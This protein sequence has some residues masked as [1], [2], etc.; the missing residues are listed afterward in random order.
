[1]NHLTRIISA[2]LICGILSGCAV[3]SETTYEPTG[4]PPS[5]TESVPVQTDSTEP[6]AADVSQLPLLS[7]FLPLTTQ[8]TYADDGVQIYSQSHQNMELLV[9]DPE[10]ASKIIIDFLNTTD[11][12]ADP[13]SLAAYA[14]QEYKSNPYFVP[15]WISET[16]NPTRFDSS[17][18]SLFGATVAYLGGAHGDYQYNSANYDLTT[19]IKLTLQD[20]LLSDDVSDNLCTLVLEELGKSSNMLFDDYSQIVKQHFDRPT[21]L[22]SNWYFS[23]AGLGIY[24]SPYEIAPFSSGVII[25]EIPYAELTDILDGAFFPSERELATASIFTQAFD[26][27]VLDRYSQFTEVTLKPGGIKSLLY[28]EGLVYD[29]RIEAGT[30]DAD[31]SVFSP[32]HTVFA[33]YTLTP[34]DAILL[35]AEQDD[36]DS[37]LRLSYT[38]Q[39]Q[40][41]YQ[42]LT[43]NAGEIQLKP[44]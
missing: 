22:I 1:M 30:W 11:I 14:E 27:A 33:A 2:L 34:G 32:Q 17:I 24:F 16:L 44:A 15:H 9:P 42:Y 21:S 35:E 43:A 18:L 12:N 10:V 39:G 37:T 28:T 23:N 7:V 29:V 8:T 3:T 36:T 6:P 19:G 25:A 40:T 4:T 41:V 31:K 20:I 38:T 5:S 13:D 26:A